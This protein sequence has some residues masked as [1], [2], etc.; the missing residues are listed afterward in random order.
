[1][2]GLGVGD[3]ETDEVESFQIQRFWLIIFV[4]PIFIA[5]IQILMLILVFPYD[6]PVV[7]KEKK[8]DATLLELMTNIYEYQLA[9]K[10]RIA[11]IYVDEDIEEGAEQ[12][13]NDRDPSCGAVCCDKKYRR[14]TFV[15]CSLSVFQQ[16]TGI[17]AIMFYSNIIFKGLSMKVVVVTALVGI[18]NFLAT[19]GGLGLLF[20]FGRKL[21]ML[22]GNA[23][24]SVTLLFLAIFAY[25]KN[26]A[27]MVT[28]LL[29]FI[30]FFEFSSGPIV[31]LYM[32]EIMRDKAVAIGT[33]LNW[34]LSLVISL[35]VPYII[36]GSS[37]GTLFLIFGI[38]TILGTLF[39]I[40]FMRETQGLN[41]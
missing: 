39:I 8:M 33:S 22:A 30:T 4:I 27:G 12:E 21:L 26:T 36:K 6:T 20:C 32:S 17:N 1:M 2:V 28:M 14:A 16:L 10:D 41:Q 29:L 7:L 9:A 23:A 19:L 3:V 11:Q 18:V 40:F 25:A 24:M 34:S 15:G 13:E 5:I 38:L 37:A 35:S 31:W